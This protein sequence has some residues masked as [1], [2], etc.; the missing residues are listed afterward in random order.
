MM[1]RSIMND[2]QIKEFDATKECNFRHRAAGHW[3]VPGQRIHPAGAGRRRYCE[4]S[5]PRSQTLDGLELPPILKDVVMNKRGLCIVVGG[6][7]SGKS[8]TLAAMIGHR[9]KNSRGHIVSIEDPVEFV[10][11]HEGLRHH[12]T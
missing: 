10:H 12:A 1:V 6:T 9:N 7:G 2:K 4:Q 3:A 8:T 11:P 5:R